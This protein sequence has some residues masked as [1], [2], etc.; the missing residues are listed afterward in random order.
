MEEQECW[1]L[2]Q[3]PEEAYPMESAVRDGTVFVECSEVAGLIG[4][5]EKEEEMVGQ[6]WAS[7]VQA[8]ESTHC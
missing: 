4:G 3:L 5:V 2:S 1:I 8:C 6:S 7:S